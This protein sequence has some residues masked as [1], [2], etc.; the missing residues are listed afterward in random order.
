MN[1]LINTRYLIVGNSAGATGAAEAIREKDRDG[2]LTIVSAEP[3]PAYSR[4]LISK[5][6]T[7]ERTIEKILFRPADFYENN[8]INLIKGISVKSINPTENTALLDSGETIA[9]EKL[10]LATGG[11]P[12]VPQISG[13]D[14]KGVF[15]F[16]NIA[17]TLAIS[18]FLK[19]MKRAVIIGGGL[20]GLSVSEALYKKGLDVTIVEL[21]DRVLNTI[22]DDT[23][24]SI[25]ADAMHKAGIKIMTGCSA[26]TIE[27]EDYVK[28]IVLDNGRILPA[29]LVIIAIG[30][31]PHIELA[32]DAGLIINRG[33]LVDR[34]MATSSADVFACGDAA[35][36]Y[37]FITERNEVVPIW[38][39]AYI[40][41]RTAGYN[42]A[43][44]ET[45]YPYLTVMN[46]LNYFGLDIVSAGAVN[47]TDPEKYEVISKHIGNTY[48]KIVIKDNR[49][50]GILCIGDIEKAGIIFG[51]MRDKLNIEPYKNV[52]LND[53]FGFAY[54]SEDIRKR[55]LGITVENPPV[56]VIEAVSGKK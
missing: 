53:D 25:A 27:G 46:S 5:L 26:T 32:Q 48:K 41:G 39:N 40:G 22:V 31:L 43:G 20:I 36:A 23:G 38:P 10:L 13:A 50:A 1:E 4:P 55:K 16:I 8:K 19:N 52:L 33:I 35:E 29:D 42:M 3:Y 34:N 37:N 28:S 18:N 44:F 9:W 15:N 7:G 49:I 24:S 51:L 21:K 2:L 47:I 17:D 14:K 30:V 6:L 54:L 12:I 56:P 45:E 11:R